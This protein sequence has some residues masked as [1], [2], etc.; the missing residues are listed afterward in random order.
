M[1]VEKAAMP[2]EQCGRFVHTGIHVGA[3]GNSKPFPSGCA[4]AALL[5]QEKAWEFLIFE[6][7]ACPLPDNQM[8]TPPPV[9][10]PGAP[11]SPPPVVS[12]PPA[13]PP[14]PPPPPPPM[15]E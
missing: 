2:T 10:P 7:S 9:P 5:P 11:N 14:P 1:P 4:T 8:P 6:L 13:P 12:Q 15:P 3:G